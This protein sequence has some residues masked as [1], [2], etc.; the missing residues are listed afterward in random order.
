MNKK[1]ILKWVFIAAAAFLFMILTFP[2][3]SLRCDKSQDVC[4]VINK[5]IIGGEQ[6]AAKFYI[7]QIA[8][9]SAFKKGNFYYPALLDKNREMYRLEVFSTKTRERSEEI[10]QHILYDEKYELKGSV[11]KVINKDY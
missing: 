4:T 2:V 3:A 5:S 7:S 9:A 1:E 8:K 10:I 6:V 11:S